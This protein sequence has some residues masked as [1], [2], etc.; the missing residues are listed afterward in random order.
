LLF[1]HIA[2][3]HP[4]PAPSRQA[5]LGIVPFDIANGVPHDLVGVEK[6]FESKFSITPILLN[7]G[8]E[9]TPMGTA[10]NNSFGRS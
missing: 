7:S 9:K 5:E 2:F 10:V 1:R 3:P 6:Y 8:Q 4:G